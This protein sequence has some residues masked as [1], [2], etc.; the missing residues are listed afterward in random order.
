MDR[1][2][3][4]SGQLLLSMPGIG[5]PRFER[6]VIA[7]CLHD[8]DGALG[9]VVNNQL[10]AL[11][12]RGLMEQLDIDPGVTPADA[13]VM[14]GGP[15]EPGRGFVL[16]SADYTGQST[17]AVGGGRGTIWGLT[18]TLDVLKDIAAGKGPRRWLATLGYTGWGAGQLEG[19]MLCHGWHL[20]PG[21][22]ALLFETNIDERWPAAFRTGG[23]D[24]GLLSAE[25]GRA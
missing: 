17:L 4:L 25:S 3:Y 22:P 15:V 14:Q 11:S 7:M 6:V 23:V 21:D 18:S 5:D 19:E 20:V 8:D 10:G 12:V 13:M 2:I 9:L 1:A 16:H 24:V